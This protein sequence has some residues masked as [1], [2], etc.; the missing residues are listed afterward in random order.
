MK[1]NLHTTFL[2][3]AFFL[4]TN[5]YSQNSIQDVDFSLVNNEIFSLDQLK[6]NVVVINIWN[7]SSPDSKKV[8]REIVDRYKNEKVVFLAITDNPYKST[9]TFLENNTISYKTMKGDEA[10]RIFNA[11]QTS[12][13]KV[14][15]IHVIIDQEGK[16]NYKKK[17]T[18]KN[19]E[20]KITKK[21]DALLSNTPIDETK[22][23]TYIT[24][25]D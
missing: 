25:N 4:F 17:G 16:L 9:I 14:F 21:I 22:V 15:P 20:N 18:V 23:T 19:I 10:E 12:M 1:L 8:P 13:F 5:A 3:M 6:G 7:P 11:Y 2:F 24:L